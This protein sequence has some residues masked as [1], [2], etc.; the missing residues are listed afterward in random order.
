[1]KLAQEEHAAVHRVPRMLRKLCHKIEILNNYCADA[2][3]LTPE[4]TEACV[5]SGLA[6]LSFFSGIVKFMRSDIVYSTP[7][8]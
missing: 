7:G 4:I 8:E 3:S 6:M 2:Q 1:M 5:D